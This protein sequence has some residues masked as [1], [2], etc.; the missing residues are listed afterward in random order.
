MYIS[1]W[2]VRESLKD[3]KV[4]SYIVGGEMCI[5]NVSLLFRGNRVNAHTLYV[6]PSEEF[7]PTLKGKTI[8]VNKN[9]YLVIY[10]NNMEEIFE[11]IQS[12]MDA[13]LEWDLEVRDLIEEKCTLQDITDRAAL[14]IRQLCC[15]QNSA[16]IIQGIS[17]KEYVKGITPQVYLDGLQSGKGM[18]MKYVLPLIESLKDKLGYKQPYLFQEPNLS[19][20]VEKGGSLVQNIYINGFFWGFCYITL[21]EQSASEV[22]KQLFHV[23]HGQL[24]R[25]WECNGV[26][27]ELPEQN[28]VFLNLLRTPEEIDK[29]ALWNYLNRIGWNR[30]DEK[31]VIRVREVFGNNLIYSRLIHEISQMYSNCYVLEYENSVVLILNASHMPLEHILR[32][33][34]YYY[35]ESNIVIGISY[36]FEDLLQLKKYLEQADIALSFAVRR[37]RKTAFCAE[38][39]V[40]YARDMLKNTVSTNLAHPVLEKLK[41]HDARHGTEYYE[42]LYAYLS[43]E[44]SVQRAAKKLNIHKNTLVFRM[45]KIKEQFGIE[46][47]DTEERMRLLISYLLFEEGIETEHS[48]P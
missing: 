31:Y 33:L 17:G 20:Y 47:D 32:Q 19:A 14:V 4:D 5:R 2:M 6:C 40:E 12:A 37:N 28:M 30:W 34:E 18:E 48:Q 44:R 35:Q 11:Q 39:S 45:G 27:A 13:Y 41:R 29:E 23:F 42:T 3:Y 46:L 25:W 24:V 8:C 9:D 26:Q 16:F 10:D 1:M 7:I 21:R 43:E 38:C 36:P 15:V 22:E